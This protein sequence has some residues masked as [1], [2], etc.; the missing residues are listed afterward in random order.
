ASLLN[1]FI[2]V[3]KLGNHPVLKSLK[4]QGVLVQVG[5]S[6]PIELTA[7]T[8]GGDTATKILITSSQ[9]FSKPIGQK[10]RPEFNP[11]TDRRETFTVGA[12]WSNQRGAK[13]VG[14]G[15]VTFLTNQM[16][17]NTGNKNFALNLV[18]WIFERQVSLS[19]RPT[20]SDYNK[21]TLTAGQVQLI[22]A[23]S[24]GL[25]PIF[26]LAWGGAVWWKRKNL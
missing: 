14:L 24:M 22:Q 8:A 20:P 3:P 6:A 11:E 5:R 26:I 4:E 16:F 9:A 19:I 25:I 10:V 23:I 15:N 12:V 13:V 18:N 1:P 21:V 2:F 17:R 7:P